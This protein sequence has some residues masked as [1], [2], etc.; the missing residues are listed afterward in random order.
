[1][2]V[3]YRGEWCPYCHLTLRTYQDQ[4]L[5]AFPEKGV[6]L[7]A[8]SPQK[9]DCS[10][11]MQEEHRLTYTVLSDPGNQIATQLGVLMPL[12]GE[13]ARQAEAK[14]GV[15][16]AAA[17][18][19]DS[20]TIPMPTTVILDAEGTIRWIDTHPDHTTRSEPTGILDALKQTIGR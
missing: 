10:L 14:L 20:E 3:S 11:A 15:D 2:V 19:D 9:P 18:A 4:L 13:A 16:V 5:Q 6:V 7:I 8:I 1:M 17:N 12:R